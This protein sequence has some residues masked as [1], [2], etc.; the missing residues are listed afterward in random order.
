METEFP[1]LPC[2]G[3]VKISSMDCLLLYIKQEAIILKI[4]YFLL[5]LSGCAKSSQLLLAE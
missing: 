1:L 5:L 3:K 4:K 2:I